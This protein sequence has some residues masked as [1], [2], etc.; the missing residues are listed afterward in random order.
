MKHEIAITITLQ[1]HNDLTPVFFDTA[2]NRK[3]YF[4]TH[5]HKMSVEVYDNLLKD[6]LMIDG[7]FVQTAPIE[8]AEQQ[9]EEIRTVQIAGK[10]V[11]NQSYQFLNIEEMAVV[12]IKPFT[13]DNAI[14]PM[15]MSA[16]LP[17][18]HIS[19]LPMTWSLKPNLTTIREHLHQTF[20]Q[21]KK[22]EPEVK[23]QEPVLEYER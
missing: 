16:N 15:K 19:F 4:D 17:D 1:A 21:L 9:G 18:R 3:N 14:Q 22:S 8:I 6:V 12:G 23:I 7:D 2:E 10:F 11:A 20:S 13:L 5:P